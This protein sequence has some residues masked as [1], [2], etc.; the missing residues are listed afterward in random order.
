MVVKAED[1]ALVTIGQQ[2]ICADCVSDSEWNDLE[3]NQ[4]SIND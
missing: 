2:D 1:V 3:Y 4:I